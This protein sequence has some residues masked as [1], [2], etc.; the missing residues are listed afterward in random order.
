MSILQ[1]VLTQ[2]RLDNKE[3]FLQAGGSAWQWGV[4]AGCVE[5]VGGKNWTEQGEGEEEKV[6]GIE[7]HALWKCCVNAQSVSSS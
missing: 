5:V 3:R 2:P 1:E 7:T 6:V 4:E